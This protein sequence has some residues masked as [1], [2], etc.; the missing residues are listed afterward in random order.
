MSCIRRN[1]AASCTG[2][3]S[4]REV[5]IAAALVA[6]GGGSMVMVTADLGILASFLW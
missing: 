6:G 5:V 4:D 3:G 2:S 1:L